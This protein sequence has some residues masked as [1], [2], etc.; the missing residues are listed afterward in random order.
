MKNIFLFLLFVLLPT[1]A[2]AAGTAL[3]TKVQYVGSVEWSAVAAWPGASHS[4]TAAGLLMSNTDNSP[5]VDSERVLVNESASCTTSSTEP[6]WTTTKGAITADNTCNW[7]E[8][9]GQPCVNGDT[10]NSPTWTASTA[11]VLGEIIYDST[12]GTC[13]IISARTGNTGA[14]K[15]SFSSTAGTT[16]SDNSGAVTWTS[17]GAASN[18]GAFAAPHARILGADA[19]TWEVAT[20][21]T[22]YISSDHAETQASAMTL[23][24][25]QGTAALPTSYLSISKTTVPPTTLTTGA[26]VATTGVNTLIVKGYGYYSGITFSAA[27]GGSNNAGLVIEGGALYFENPTFTLASTYATGAI[28]LQDNS[29]LNPLDGVVWL[30]NPA[31]TFSATG[32]KINLGASSG[33]GHVISI[34]GS[35]AATGSVPTTLF[36]DNGGAWVDATFRDIDLSAITGTLFTYTAAS[37]GFIRLEDCKLASGVTMTSETLTDAGSIKFQ[38]HNCDSGST[39]Y[40]FY[41]KDYLGTLQQSTSEVDT[42][43]AATDGHT[44]IS[45]SITTSA[46]TTFTQPYAMEYFPEIAWYDT[47]GSSVTATIEIAG[48]QSLNNAQ[49]WPECE[50]LSTSGYPLGVAT[51]GRAS[52]V[53]STPTTWSTS[54]DSWTGSPTYTQ[55]MTVSFTPQLSGQ[56]KCRVYVADPSITEYVSPRILLGSQTSGRQYIMPGMGYINEGPSSGGSG[57]EVGYAAP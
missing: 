9:T 29:A 19:A 11:T 30:I 52:N 28:S 6:T 10:T 46:N 39:Q 13:Q 24:G 57:G 34:G 44:E 51:S 17:L 5:A 23:A 33:G 3:Q 35:V 22:L 47:T 8:V 48:A 56:V 36:G 18:F 38:A 15:P 40:K 4:S 16:T 26:S 2:F 54:A 27:G 45:W 37:G 21:A 31:F 7:Q 41:D 32:Q 14:S 12:S 42:T 25:G 43:N 1:S 50:N 53:L 20:P 49:I 55:Y